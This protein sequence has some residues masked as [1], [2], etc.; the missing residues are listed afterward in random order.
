MSQRDV[1]ALI[2]QKESG[3]SRMIPNR[4]SVLFGH[5]GKLTVQVPDV[6]RISP[7]RNERMRSTGQS[8]NVYG[9]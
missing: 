5:T 1:F 9:I 2:F 7:Y 4:H 3:D 6:L 8:L